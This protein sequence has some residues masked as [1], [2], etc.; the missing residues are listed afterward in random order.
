MSMKSNLKCK[1]KFDSLIIKVLGF[2]LRQNDKCILNFGFI[3]IFHFYGSNI[4]FF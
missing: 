3:E 1:L 4:F 2:G